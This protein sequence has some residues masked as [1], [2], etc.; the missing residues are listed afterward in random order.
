MVLVG[1]PRFVVVVV[2]GTQKRSSVAGF[3]LD[4]YERVDETENLIGGV[5]VENE[6]HRK[7]RGRRF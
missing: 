5:D 1:T 3:V 7:R 6:K 4:E 2:V